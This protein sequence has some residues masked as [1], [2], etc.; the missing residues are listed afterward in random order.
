M[1]RFTGG[2]QVKHTDLNI[3][4]LPPLDLQWWTNKDGEMVSF[5]LRSN[6]WCSIKGRGQS[7][8]IH[9]RVCF[10]RK[11]GA[12]STKLR[13]SPLLLLSAW[14]SA[15]H[16][17]SSLGLIQWGVFFL[18]VCDLDRLCSGRQEMWVM[19]AMCVETPLPSS[20]SEMS[21]LPSEPRVPIRPAHDTVYSLLV[22]TRRKVGSYQY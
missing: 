21:P 4:I 8:P 10:V 20:H 12:Q 19:L 15:S 6:M 22:E 14:V 13:K 3:M 2:H 17:S 1:F 11:Y 18:R 7:N 16:G 5:S 9:P